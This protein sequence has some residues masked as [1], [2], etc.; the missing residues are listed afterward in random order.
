MGYSILRHAETED[1][2]SSR[3]AHIW[4]RT[5]AKATPGPSLGEERLL[6]KSHAHS[7]LV[8]GRPGGM[9][10][11]AAI[12]STKRRMFKSRI[13]AP[14]SNIFKFAQVNIFPR[15]DQIVNKVRKYAEALLVFFEKMRGQRVVRTH[16]A[17]HRALN[18]TG[19]ASF[20]RLAF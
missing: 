5:S 16:C 13:F 9:R 7:G 2:A 10:K 18:R 1:A 20:Q 6:P 19:K 8:F 17:H 14:H 3:S 15:F 11:F 12:A 4:F